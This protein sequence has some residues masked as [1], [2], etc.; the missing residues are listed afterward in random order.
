MVTGG[1]T[2]VGGV[3]VSQAL[4]AF[5]PDLGGI[6]LQNAAMR[7]TQTTLV[8]T[9][10]IDLTGGLTVENGGM[11]VTGGISS[12]TAGFIVTGGISVVSTI[13]LPNYDF[14]F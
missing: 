9:S 3:V 14:Y 12:S 13:D 10:G 7:V 11:K 8:Q 1:V 5:L 6:S 4:P 2:V